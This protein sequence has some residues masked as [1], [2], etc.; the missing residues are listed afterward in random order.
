MSHSKLYIT[1]INL[2]L[3]LFSQMMLLIL[4]IISSVMFVAHTL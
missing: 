4:I 2:R 1:Y 3:V